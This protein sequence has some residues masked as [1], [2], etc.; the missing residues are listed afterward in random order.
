MRALERPAAVRQSLIAQFD[1][2]PL[3]TRFALETELRQP[4]WLAARGTLAH[5]FFQVAVDWMREHEEPS[6]PVDAAME[7]LQLVVAQRDVPDDEVVHLPMKELRWL[8]V[9]ATKFA[10]NHSY[11]VDR[12]VST[13]ERYYATIPVYGPGDTSYAREISGQLDVLLVSP[14]DGATVVDYKTGFAPAPRQY[15]KPD[16]PEREDTLSDLGYAQQ[17]IYG[18]LVMMNFP[19]VQWVKLRE[20]YVLSDEVREA[21]VHRWEMERIQDV[22]AGIVAQFDAAVDSE[23]RLHEKAQQRRADAGNEEPLPVSKLPHSKRFFPVPGTHCGM[24]PRPRDCPIREEV[25]IPA[26]EEDAKRVAQEW[27]VA[28]E[29]R[30]ERLKY[31]KAWVDRHGPVEIEHAKGRRAVGWVPNATG[32][33]RSFRLYQPQDAPESPFDPMLAA[34]A[35]ERGAL[36]L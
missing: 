6:I 11:S 12:I 29:V 3:S 9:I 8:R 4:G 33:G 7:L 24:C 31:V 16:Q 18:F 14:P 27:I 1:R 15:E 10:Y 26:T 36:V 19:S 13:E 2:C 22:L 20:Y 34:A 17:V 28:G 32:S 35:R 21:T 30:S 5:R 25:G 23:L